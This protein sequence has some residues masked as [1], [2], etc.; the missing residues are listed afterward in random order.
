MYTFIFQKKSVMTIGETMAYLEPYQT[1]TMEIFRKNSKWLKV[2][3]YFEN[4][5]PHRCLTGS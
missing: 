3:H 4:M 1:S 5:H 2:A